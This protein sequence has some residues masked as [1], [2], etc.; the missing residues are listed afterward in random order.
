MIVLYDEENKE[1]AQKL[2]ETLENRD[3]FLTKQCQIDFVEGIYN[4]RIRIYIDIVLNFYFFIIYS[5]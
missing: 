1:K 2:M 4:I 3:I 5:F